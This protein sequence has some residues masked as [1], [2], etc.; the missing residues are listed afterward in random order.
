[1]VMAT[2]MP[3]RRPEETWARGDTRGRSQALDVD[4]RSADRGVMESDRSR[5]GRGTLAVRPVVVVIAAKAALMLA[6]SGRYGW[7]RDELYYA[8]AGRHCRDRVPLV[9]AGLDPAIYPQ[10]IGSGC[11]GTRLAGDR[12]PPQA[13]PR[14]G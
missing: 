4:P 1:M 7:H 3:T 12:W 8:V 13:R 9:M 10:T 5:R 2:I 6:V 14:R 11:N